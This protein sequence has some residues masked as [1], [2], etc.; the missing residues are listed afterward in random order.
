MNPAQKL[1]QAGQSLWLD[2][3][4]RR[5]LTSGTLARYIADLAVTGLTSNPTILGHA[6]AASTDYDDSLR[7]QVAAG[8]TGPQELVYAVAMEDLT[9][10]A[11]LFRPAWEAT[12]GVDGYVS[13]EVPPGLAYE[14][15]QSIEAARRL[16][17]QA[18]RPNLLVKI[19]GTP[20][21]LTALEQLISEGVGINVTLLFSD[22]HYLRTADAYLRGLERR[23][24]EGLP[25]DVPSVA[26]LFVSRWDKAADPLLPASL[27]GRLGL[28]VTQKAYASHR[29]L[30]ESAR[31]KALQAAGAKP[32]RL[33]W[34]STSTKD[35]AFP[36][37]YYL[38]KLAAPD[39]IDTVPEKT[40]LAFA[41][42]GGS[43]ELMRPDY[44]AAEKCL[45]EIAACRVD[46]DALAESLQ[47]EG[48]RAFEAD[49]AALLE[50]ISA[51]ASRLA[52]S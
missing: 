29:S 5:L 16:H 9:A 52:A 3:I 13:V 10:A 23:A 18:S 6:M 8:A 50:A 28:A 43:V 15:Q 34:A 37:T 35:P 26:S 42:H 40:L 49:W 39:T 33:L 48:A 11:D 24:A 31:W 32:Q 45:A 1:H 38:G 21:G 4:S 2:S 22:S 46:L 17:Q 47:R 30:Q 41:D 44:A 51:K 12:G 25:L 7:R 27:H 19:P 36:D 14:P 20:P